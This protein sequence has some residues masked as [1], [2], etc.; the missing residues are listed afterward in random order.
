MIYFLIMDCVYICRPGDNDELRYSIRSVVKNLPHDNIW[1]VGY[2][3]PWYKGNYVE[4]EDKTIK[5]DNIRR[6]LSAIT[7]IGAISDDFILMNDDFYILKPMGLIPTYHGGLLDKKIERYVS[8]SGSTRYTRILGEASKQLKKR[9]IKE[10]LDYDIHTPMIM[11]K[12]K[13][14]QIVNMNMAPRSM[15]GNIYEIGG[16]EIEDVKIYKYNNAI[17]YSFGVISTEDNSLHLIKEMLIK[18]FPNPS[19]YELLN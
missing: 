7:D 12:H 15:Y 18:E 17:D 9:G 10:P 5:F 1:I 16:K 2:K 3:P 14:K 6:C 4:V 19:L 8:D 13:L 11:N